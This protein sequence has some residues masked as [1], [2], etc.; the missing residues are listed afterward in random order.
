MVT[1]NRIW[2]KGSSFLGL[3]KLLSAAP[4]MMLLALLTAP[5]PPPQPEITSM[6]EADKETGLYMPFLSLLIC[7]SLVGF[8]QNNG[9]V[10]RREL[11][12]L[13]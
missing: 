13:G 8:L 1:K 4:W 6:G 9:T 2:Y 3:Q 7:L 12:L 10:K 11:L 5:V